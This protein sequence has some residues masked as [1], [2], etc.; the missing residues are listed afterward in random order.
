MRLSLSNLGESSEASRTTDLGLRCAHGGRYNI[1]MIE[2]KRIVV[3]FRCRNSVC[4]IF[5]KP[6]S[7]LATRTELRE[8]CQPQST[9]KFMCLGCGDLFDLTDEEKAN[10]LKMLN[11]EAGSKAV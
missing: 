11:E 5:Q 2:E 6:M 7:H 8:M 3:L 4:A 1:C 9:K 10:T